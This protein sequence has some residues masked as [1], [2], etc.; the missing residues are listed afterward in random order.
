MS[1]CNN[2]RN[3]LN[4]KNHFYSKFN[5]N[6][7]YYLERN[8][9]PRFTFS[10]FRHCFQRANIRLGEIQCFILSLLNTS[11][12]KI[13]RGEKNPVYSIIVFT[14]DRDP[15]VSFWNLRH[16]LGGPRRVAGRCVCIWCKGPSHG[17]CLFEC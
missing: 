2:S 17:L 3:Q 5:F 6:F 4:H 9:R 1:H 16:G 13:T 10:P 14:H 8:I 11:R 15:S 12:A 7:N